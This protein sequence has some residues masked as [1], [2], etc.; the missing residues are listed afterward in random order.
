M[1]GIDQLIADIR[2]ALKLLTKHTPLKLAV[3][4]T[5]ALGIGANTAMFTVLEALLF[6]K[7]PY[8]NASELVIFQT[9]SKNG[10]TLEATSYPRFQEWKKVAHSMREIAGLSRQGLILSG[11]GPAEPLRA[12]LVTPDYFPTL[13][14]IPSEGRTF[15]QDEAAAPGSGPVAILSDGLWKRHFGG[16]RDVLGKTIHLNEHAFT[17]VGILPAGFQ[18]ISQ[19]AEVWIPIT[20][21]GVVSTPQ[22][23]ENQSAI[24]VTT[25][26]RLS[27]GTSVQSAQEELNLIGEHATADSSTGKRNGVHL[28][29]LQSRSLE[30]YKRE[31]YVL[32]GAVLFILLIASLNVSNLLLSYFSDRK[33]ELAVRNALGAPRMRLFRQLVTESVVLSI[34][35]GS[36]GLMIAM[37]VVKTLGHSVSAV[38]AG[39]GPLSVDG[40]V[41]LFTTIISLLT[42]T[43]S[44]LIPLVQIL[45][46]GMI[47]H[48]KSQ[49][50]TG[51]GFARSRLRTV[52]VIGQIGLA[53]VLVV[54]AGLM[55][56]SM[57]NLRNVNLGFNSDHVLIARLS[58][59]A[60]A[61]Y[62]T[63]EK[64]E[65]FYEA[66]LGKLSGLPQVRA[67]G[68]V[69][70]PPLL[71]PS[72]SIPFLVRGRSDLSPNHPPTA[73]YVV[74][75]YGY[76]PTISVPLLQGREFEKSDASKTQ[77]V[78]IIN[79]SMSKEFWPGESPVGQYLN[80]FDGSDT[81]KQIIGVVANFRDSSVDTAS[82]SEMYV[83]YPQVPP[84]FVSLLKSFPP[85]VAIKTG[86]MAESL[87]D[88]VRAS[89]LELEPNEAV[90]SAATLE[91]IISDSVSEPRL[92]SQI[93]GFFAAMALGLAAIGI[94]GVVSYS[95]AQRRQELGVRMALGANRK[96]I[97]LLILGQSMTFTLIGV[98]LGAIGALALGD[99]LRS[100]LFEIRPRDPGTLVL[101]V[102][103]LS[104][105]AML[106]AYVPARRASMV[107]P[108]TA[109]KQE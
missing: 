88:S 24:W 32:F 39:I 66:L 96:K 52:L 78:V 21:I 79:E 16:Q 91:S 107:D 40:R 74:V 70:S 64:M 87:A 26:G 92:Y 63:G 57:A 12:E 93:L 76:F 102:L 86:A 62:D 50:R 100:L 37:A 58:A 20:M 106:A 25:I 72:P 59:L 31:S 18:G 104:A 13:G 75:S 14:I 42:G 81:P 19:K 98:T 8:T 11:D 17:V 94:Y 6:P 89:V 51:T 101:A 46:K 36:L 95:V 67:T 48:L 90:L 60:G 5:L 28:G 35:G 108:S 34:I 30:R 84:A 2:L 41:F 15:T 9:Y 44:G 3:I 1:F 99:V 10:Q 73:Q 77:P 55:L 105:V 61:K 29:L 27:E 83:P 68:V 56:R 49:S 43:V 38:L 54:G 33:G 23:L 7:L 85:A 103:S 80:I 65:A 71:A 69:S 4:A 109:L 22:L 47:D 97:L 82:V 45:S 53:V